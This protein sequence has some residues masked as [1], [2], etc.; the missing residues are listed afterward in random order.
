MPRSINL[1]RANQRAY[2][3]SYRV[4][5]TAVGT[6]MPSEVFV[7]R[8]EPLDPSKPADQN[9]D[10]YDH[11][12]TPA[13]LTNLRVGSP[14]AGETTFRSATI[15]RYYDQRSDVSQNIAD[16]DDEWALFQT[17]IDYL[18]KALNAGDNTAPS[19]NVTL[20]GA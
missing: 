20:T 12:A 3:Q 10:V 11:V 4:T 9:R 8:R 18:I 14:I 2:D 16:A 13:E 7:M 5:Y 17:E 1:T 15:V 6:S 19:Q